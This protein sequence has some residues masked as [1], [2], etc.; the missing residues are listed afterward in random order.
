MLYIAEHFAQMSMTDSLVHEIL[1]GNEVLLFRTIT[2]FIVLV[3]YAI[4]FIFSKKRGN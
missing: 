4:L 2:I 3:T 1:N